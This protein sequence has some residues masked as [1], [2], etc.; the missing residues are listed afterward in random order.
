MVGGR[1]LRLREND[2]ENGLLA[3]GGSGTP[4]GIIGTLLIGIVAGWIAEKTTNT[5]MGLIRNLITGLIGSV[6][7]S[8][9]ANAL[10]INI[11]EFFSGWFWGNV[12]VSTVG[13]II[14][15]MVLKMIFGRR[16]A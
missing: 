9:L 16:T 13:A 14:F 15:L 5:D 3:L 4:V 12:L 6:I 10:G 11:A 8:A 1:H 7:G 2:M